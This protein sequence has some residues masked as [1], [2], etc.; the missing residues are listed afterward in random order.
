MKSSGDEDEMQAWDQQDGCVEISNGR[1]HN[2]GI[3]AWCVKNNALK[4]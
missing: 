2:P 4:I 3:V 1:F